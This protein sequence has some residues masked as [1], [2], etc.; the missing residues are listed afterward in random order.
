MKQLKNIYSIIY[1]PSHL[2]SPC[3]YT[4][5]LQTTSHQVHMVYGSMTPPK[6]VLG[7]NKNPNTTIKP[8]VLSQT[9]LIMPL[10]YLSS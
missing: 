5:Y 9:P 4:K 10:H 1:Y 7:I 3:V 6:N 2:N 8:F